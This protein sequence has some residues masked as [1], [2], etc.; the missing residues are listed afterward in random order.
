MLCPLRGSHVVDRS[1]L[2]SVHVLLRRHNDGRAHELG[3]AQWVREGNTVRHKTITESA[4]A[5]V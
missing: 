2:A 5:V 3:Q 1:A 4:L